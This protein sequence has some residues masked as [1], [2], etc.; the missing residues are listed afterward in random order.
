MLLKSMI[1]RIHRWSDEPV[2]P[3]CRHPDRW[4]DLRYGAHLPDRSGAA[5]TIRSRISRP[6]LSYDPVCKLLR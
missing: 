1:K 3:E 6:P 2:G 5:V 4:R